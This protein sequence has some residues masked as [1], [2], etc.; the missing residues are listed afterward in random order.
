MTISRQMRRKLSTTSCSRLTSR[1][2]EKTKLK[3][4]K[5]VYSSRNIGLD[6]YNWPTYEAC[7]IHSMSMEFFTYPWMELFFEHETDKYKFAHLASSITFLPYGVAVDEFQHYVYE[8][9]EATA[10]ERKA[11]EAQLKQAQHTTG[12][13]SA[14]L[15]ISG[16]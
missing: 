1:F 5:E 14:L 13:A 7:D 8:N 2:R 10:D 3:L 4:P 6:E 12:Y 15:K 11:A 9:P 16:D